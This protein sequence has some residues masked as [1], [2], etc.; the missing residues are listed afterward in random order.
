[1]ETFSKGLEL[2][3][4]AVPNLQRAAVLSNPANPAHTLSL[5][6]IEA[7]AQRLN[8]QLQKLE[9]RGPDEFDSAFAAMASARADAV[10]IVPDVLS[11]EHSGRLGE[12]AL[13]HGLPSMH[14]F[15]EEVEAGGLL[16]YGPNFSEPRRRAAAFVDKLLKGA[17]AAELP[18]Q[19]P[20][21]FEFAIN[22]KTARA[23]GLT[24]PSTLL[25][26]ADEV[27]E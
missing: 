3:K 4:E 2:L 9:A 22:L 25:A 5:R 15:S 24:I 12:L 23:L 18:V 26:R 10:M 14:G 6:S 16:S 21:K 7:A 27:I 8:V 1:L 11:V 20:T 19:Q 13:M 17:N